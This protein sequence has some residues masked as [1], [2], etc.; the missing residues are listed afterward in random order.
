MIKLIVTCDIRV[1]K[2]NEFL[3][4]INHDF[5]EIMPTIGL[6]PSEA[7]YA[8]WS[9]GPRAVLCSLADDQAALDLILATVEWA[10]LHARLQEFATNLTY[11][12]TERASGFQI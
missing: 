6:Q 9:K 11:K 5:A 10:E 2:E 7:W 8:P 4:F 12:V 1:G 3:E